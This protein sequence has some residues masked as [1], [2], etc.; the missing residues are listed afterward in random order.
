MS[1]ILMLRMERYFAKARAVAN[2]AN[3][4]GRMAKLPILNHDQA[5]FISAPKI[6]TPTNISITKA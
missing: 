5:P 6:K 2:L 3:S 4:E 1:L